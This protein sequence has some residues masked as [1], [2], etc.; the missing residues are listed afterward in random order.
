MKKALIIRPEAET[1]LAEA[2]AWYEERVP[3]LGSDFLL[4]VDAALASV[5]RNPEM[6]P[7]YVQERSTLPYSVLSLWNILHNREG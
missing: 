5:Q 6:Y 2:F 4:S 1:D 3:G 7:V